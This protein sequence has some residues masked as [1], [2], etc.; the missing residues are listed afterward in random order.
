MFAT[1]FPL[2]FL[3]LPVLAVVLAL[4]AT[5]A[6]EAY[7]W[8]KCG[9]DRRTW[10]HDSVVY[11]PANI[12]F[13]GSFK[14]ALNRSA[15]AWNEVPGSQFRFNLV[16]DDATT[17]RLGDGKNSIGFT[18]D[19]DFGDFIAVELTDYETCFLINDGNIQESDILFNNDYTWESSLN[20][21][22]FSGSYNVAL[23][24][25][26]EMGH[27]LGL[28]HENAR[29]A[30]MNSNFPNGG[31]FGNNHVVQIH[32]DDALGSRVGYGTCCTRR[33]VAASVFEKGTSGFSNLIASPSV[34]ERGHSTSFKFTL[35]NRGTVS[36]SSVRT[37][38]YLSTNRT[39]TTGDTFLGS[40]TFSLGVG[41]SSTLSASVTIP[42]SVASGSYFFGVLA[43]ANSSIG[44][45]DESN[46]AAGL[47]GSVFVPTTSHPFACLTALPTSGAEPLRVSFN[48]SCSSDPDGS[49]VSY[50]WDFDDGSFGSGS[51]TSHVFDAGT[52]FVRLTV[53]DDDGLTDTQ[54]ISILVTG[55][56]GCLI[57]DPV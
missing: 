35:E 22:F 48:A 30:T 54:F 4:F 28:D 31:V 44:E 39:I 20:P 17:T 16:Y 2:R 51:T 56:S 52:Y 47:A 6:A 7:D 49:I 40:A 33:D 11:N 38:F 57:C 46:N 5:G 8:P 21:F 27:G 32:A 1:R 9:G 42:L 25:A 43:D 41:A 45:V 19:Y 37:N 29:L 14:T 18:T 3:S 23:V 15:A 26:H 12:S 34:V 53:T 36:E 13:P 10:N 55:S 24:G 50:S